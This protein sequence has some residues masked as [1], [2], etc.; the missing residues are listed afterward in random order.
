L[1]LETPILLF[2]KNLQAVSTGS[3]YVSLYILTD[4]RGQDRRKEM[5]KLSEAALI[6]VAKLGILVSL[7]L[8]LYSKTQGK[9]YN[10][11]I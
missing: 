1:A 8:M 7:E 2:S 6:E 5:E 4:S 10:A 11:S 3:F 9:I